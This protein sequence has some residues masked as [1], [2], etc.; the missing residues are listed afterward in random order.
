MMATDVENGAAIST[1]KP[2]EEVAFLNAKTDEVGSCNSLKLS[3]I[4]ERFYCDAL[5]LPR[6]AETGAH[7][8]QFA[9]EL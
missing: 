3:P 8:A 9:S 7:L 4:T 1:K 6:V 2:V 5:L